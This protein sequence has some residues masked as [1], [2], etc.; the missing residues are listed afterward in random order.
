LNYTKSVIIKGFDND[1][2]SGKTLKTFRRVKPLLKGHANRRE[3]VLSVHEFEPL[4]ANAQKHLQGILSMGYWTGMRKG[5]IINLTWD[6]V[7]LKGRLIRLHASDTKEKESKAVPVGDELFKV[8]SRIPTPIHGGYVFLYN[9]K[10]ITKRFETA[11]KS[12]C[13]DAGLTWGRDEDG[14]LIFHDLRHTFI[15]DMRRAGVPRTVTM[16]ITGHAIRDM[17]ERYDFVEDW[18]KLEAIKKLETYR[19]SGMKVVRE[20][21][22]VSDFTG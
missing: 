20:K 11:M 16:A 1:M 4:H 14:G 18:E 22:N 19:K 8:L 5:E 17:N 2:I 3:R 10:P 15:T 12:A 6:K 21:T 7:D 13:E 9:G